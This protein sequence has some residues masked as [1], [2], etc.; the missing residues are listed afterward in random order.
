LNEHHV[1]PGE[2][3]SRIE[4]PDISPKTFTESGSDFHFLAVHQLSNTELET[5]QHEWH[6]VSTV[7]SEPE[8]I[9]SHHFEDSGELPDLPPTDQD[10]ILSQSF[11]LHSDSDNQQHDTH[12]HTE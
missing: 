5:L 7:E 1:T 8:G 9:L 10:P 2:P 12:T 6:R 4:L 3:R 11:D